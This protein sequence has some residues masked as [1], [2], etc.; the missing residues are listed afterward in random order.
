MFKSNA[1]SCLTLITIPEYNCATS[2]L[3]LT[4]SVVNT[5]IAPPYTV[6][7]SP[8]GIN[9]VM[10]TS[11]IILTNIPYNPSY[12]FTVYTTTSCVYVGGANYAPPPT[13]SLSILVTPTNV[14][15]FGGNNGAASAVYI[16]GVAPFTYTWSTGSNNP[17][18]S[19]L[20]IG[21][22]SVS[23]SDSKNCTATR[24][25]T[26]TEPAQINSKLTNTF[27]PCF[28]S[29]ITSAVSSTGGVAPFN[30][31]VSGTPVAT[32]TNV[33]TNLS[34]G[35]QTILTKDSKSCLTTNTILIDQANQQIIS[36]NIQQPS[37]P[38]YTNGSISVNVTGPYAGYSYT[39]Q[40]GGSNSIS[41]PN[42]PAGSYSL[43]VKDATNCITYSVFTVPQAPTITPVVG[44]NKEN[45]SA[46]DGS[47]TLSLSGGHPP[48]TYTTN[49]GNITT[50]VGI[51]L[52]SDYY[53][54]FITDANSC[55]DTLKFY[56]GN[57]S[58]VSLTA[59]K[60]NSVECYNT[61]NGS[62]LCNVQ[63]AVAPI[64]YSITGFPTSTI[65]LLSNLCAGNYI[66]YAIDAIG[67]PA[68][69]TINF[70][71]P[72]VF[73]Y[74]AV[75][76]PIICIGKQANLIGYAQGG[77]GAHTY[78]WNPGNLYG[79]TVQVN[80]TVTTVYY[81]NVYDSK[82]CTLAPYQVTVNVNPP[83]SIT[84][85]S[86]NSGICPGTT[87][88]ITP[89][90]NGG[91]G[92]YSYLWLP[93]GSKGASIYVA[94]LSIPT[95]SFF[96]SDACGSPPAFEVINL[97]LFPV[98]RPTCVITNTSGCLPLCAEFINTTPGSS[99]AIWNYGDKPFEKT[100]DQTFYCYD[101]SGQYN[102]KLSV[103][104]SNSCKASYTYTNAVQVFEKPKSDYILSPELITMNNAENVLF[105][106]L[107]DNATEYKWYVNNDFISSN[108]DTYYSFRD[109][110]F[111]DIKLV[112]KNSYQCKDS[113]IRSM[114][115]FE[116]FSFYM[117]NA[118]SPNAD[119][120][121]DVLLPKGVALQSEGYSFEVFNKWGH[122]IFETN[123]I[124]VGW[125]G[126]IK[127]EYD[128]PKYGT[129][130]P[131]DVYVWKILVTD[132]TQVKH[133]YTGTV[134]VLR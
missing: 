113:V 97:N 104:D 5:T 16:V 7:S 69:D 82:N 127:L 125:D 66:V 123:Q 50:S 12:S 3:E 31:T 131:N 84:I 51:G 67:C 68:T 53:T 32:G 107:S 14:S 99:N 76:P 86:S 87:A 21:V 72:P 109:T 24:E 27:I 112:S 8:A 55:K 77:T 48:F 37:C 105:H 20:S 94:N 23:I 61:C 26:V 89:T 132:N 98:T 54:T 74:S 93:G 18:I 100:G 40:P 6:T 83:I 85:N 95:Y 117:P 90:V 2:A 88:Q 78:L 56:I 81:L 35:I 101:R 64:T 41:L 128:D 102:L 116:G 75:P 29:T 63:N 30:Y 13:S 28:G 10:T 52:S 111:Y 70:P 11:S 4:L 19:G 118:F 114:K 71:T 73:S 17:I 96:V 110:G 46:V 126:G 103:T 42:V 133:E 45:C 44:I 9:A 119:G 124:D 22:Y 33:A 34:A 15:C 115:V 79:S 39:W 1:Q 58:T 130:N 92:N 57:L 59:I 91:D 121:N 43:S 120:L 25:F 106:N 36:P 134:L 65:N 62:V 129:C 122:R 47:F 80:P 108:F 60:V 49:P 38:G